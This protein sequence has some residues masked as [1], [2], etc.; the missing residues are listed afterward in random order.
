MVCARA[1]IVQ[2]QLEDVQARKRCSLRVD[3]RNQWE[4][5]A[6]D[7]QRAADRGDMRELY[8]LARRLGAFK[9]TPVPGVKRKDG[10]LTSDDFKG[11]RDGRSTLRRCLVASKWRE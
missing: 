9:P 10:T 2:Q 3:R 11:L 5:I 8:K 1:A 7:A 6:G 4:S